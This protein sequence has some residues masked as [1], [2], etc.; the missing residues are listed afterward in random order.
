MNTWGLG[1]ISSNREGVKRYFHFDALGSTRALTDSTG[2]VT[3]TYEYNAFGVV[4]SSTGTSTNPFRYVGQYGYYDDGAMGSLSVILW[5]IEQRPYDMTFNRFLGGAGAG[6]FADKTDVGQGRFRQ[7]ESRLQDCCGVYVCDLHGWNNS[8]VTHRYICAEA[9]GTGCSGGMYP[10]GLGDRG[11][12]TRNTGCK[13][14]TPPPGGF[15]RC[16]LIDK[17]CEIARAVCDELNS[18]RWDSGS[19]WWTGGF[20]WSF[21]GHLLSYVCDRAYKRGSREWRECCQRYGCRCPNEHRSGE[22]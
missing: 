16:Y 18:G 8:I 21:P 5:T 17:R 22:V 6:M 14:Q 4:E 13:N 10:G 9:C 7:I 12:W 19:V 2:S 1:L 3:D 20:C 11:Y 15:I